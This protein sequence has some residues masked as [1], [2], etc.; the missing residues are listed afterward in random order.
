[1]ATYGLC[2]NAQSEQEISKCVYI[3]GQP[4]INGNIARYI[5]SSKEAYFPNPS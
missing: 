4:K 5:N 2:G 3:E 1:M